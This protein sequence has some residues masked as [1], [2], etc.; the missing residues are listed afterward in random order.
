MLY[1]VSFY[2]EPIKV[3]AED[4]V[5]AI[6]EARRRVFNRSKRTHRIALIVRELQRGNP[7]GN[8]IANCS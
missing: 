1:R 6:K 4:D 7:N 5:S 8:I 2:T 3:S